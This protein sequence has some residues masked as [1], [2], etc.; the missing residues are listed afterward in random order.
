M[1]TTTHRTWQFW[2]TPAV[3]LGIGIG[4]L[5]AAWAGGHPGLGVF[6]LAIMVVAA[7]GSVLLARRSETVHGL[8]EHRDE[9]LSTIDLTATAAAGMAVIVA[10]LV[11]VLVELARG[12]DAMPYAWLGA[13]GGASYVVAV[14]VLRVRG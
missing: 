5:A 13:I 9:R 8:M 12:G 2:A 1:P 14:V 10:V 6:M 11:G 4:Y 3:A 7:V